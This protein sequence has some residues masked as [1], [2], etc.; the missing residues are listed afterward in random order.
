MEVS[1]LLQLHHYVIFDINLSFNEVSTDYDET[2][3][4]L[5]NVLKHLIFPMNPDKLNNALT[6]QM[7]YQKYHFQLK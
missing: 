1:I 5:G 3:Y 2:I 7:K 6:S 4:E